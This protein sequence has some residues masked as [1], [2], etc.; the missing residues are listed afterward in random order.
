[1]AM[2]QGKTAL[3]TGASRGIGHFLADHGRL[4]VSQIEKGANRSGD[5]V[6]LPGR[7]KLDPHVIGQQAVEPH[8]IRSQIPGTSR[9]D[10]NTLLRGN[11]GEHRLHH[12]WLALNQRR[13]TGISAHTCNRVE[14]TG[15]TF[16]MK[17]DEA[18]FSQIRNTHAFCFYTSKAASCCSGV[19]SRSI[20]L[21]PG[22]C[23]L[24]V[25]TISGRNT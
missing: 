13:K 12:I 24:K 20:I 5:V 6:L 22:Y 15:S 21:I 8:A 9:N 25:R 23:A 17:Q 3:V 16:T 2:L 4:C 1:M 7:H 19:S 18:V 11:E 10:R 14:Q